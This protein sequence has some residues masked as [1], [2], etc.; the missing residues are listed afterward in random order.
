MKG[1]IEMRLVLRDLN[2]STSQSVFLGPYLSTEERKEFA[3]N[4]MCMND[5]FLSFP[6]NVPGTA[7]HR[8][9]KARKKVVATLTECARKSKERMAR[10]QEPSCLLDFW[11]TNTIKEIQQAQ[12]EGLPAPPHSTNE[13]IGNTTLDFLFAAQDASTASLVWTTQFIAVSSPHSLTTQR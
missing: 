10:D 3:D 9:V 6:L 13:E 2:V 8:A 7:L 1:P 12:K 4:Y 11:M 5:G